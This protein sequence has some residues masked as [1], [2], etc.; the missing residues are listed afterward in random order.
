MNSR[1][2]DVLEDSVKEVLETSYAF[3]KDESEDDFVWDLLR[4]CESP[5]EQMMY[6][7]LFDLFYSFSEFFCPLEASISVQKEV[8]FKKKKF[9]TDFA[10]T[11]AD[12][13]KFGEGATC[14]YAIECDG[15]EF[16]EKTKEQARSDR[17]RERDLMKLGYKV[18]RFTGS[19]IYQDAFGC[20]REVIKIILANEKKLLIEHGLLNP[21]NRQR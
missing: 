14:T 16:H 15:H 18:I 6:I 9:R 21:D 7:A 13:S 20:A 5:I 8:T 17:S 10:L 3:P 11:I 2:A 1:L 4:K 19:E 12:T